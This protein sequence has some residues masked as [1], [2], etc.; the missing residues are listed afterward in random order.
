[1]TYEVL[2]TSLMTKFGSILSDNLVGVYLHGSYVMGG[3]NPK[4]SDIDFLIVVKEDFDY[5]E[6]K[7]II[8]VLLEFDQFSPAKGLEMSIMALKDTLKPQRPTPFFLHYSDFHK[9]RYL[10]DANYICSGADDPDL[11]AHLSV[12]KDRGVC[13]V[14]QPI[15]E[16]FGHVP[17]AYYLDAIMYDLNDARDEIANSF[18]YY[19][20]NLSRTLYY[21]KEN[22][23]SSKLDG[24][25]WAIQNIPKEFT[26]VI[27]EAIKKYISKSNESSLD[28][29]LLK[30][31]TMYM[32]T[33]IDDLILDGTSVNMVNSMQ[34]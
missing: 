32:F 11:L 4:I 8:K 5:K 9:E 31:F 2:L 20:L 10:S 22:V 24:G 15:D 16:V 25:N 6:K 1:M 34:N 33:T 18:E 13:A 14:G 28:K 21:L 17:R 26:P 23:I 19:V 27:E 30:Q 7:E 12:I 29:V 3:F